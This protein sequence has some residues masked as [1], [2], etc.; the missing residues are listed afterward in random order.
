[1]RSLLPFLCLL[2]GAC[3]GPRNLTPGT[4][5]H[6]SGSLVPNYRHLEFWAAHPWKADPSDSLPDALRNASR[7]TLA[8]VFFI[9]PTTYTGKRNG[10]NADLSDEALNH[11]TD[12]STILY[13]ASVFNQHA[14]VFAPRYRQAH[15]SAFFTQDSM[16]RAA[17]DTAYADVRQAFLTYLQFYNGGRP[18]IIAGHSQGAL[19]S[20]WL[21]REFFDGKDLKKQLVAAYIIGWP[22]TA[23]E[24]KTIPI[25][26]DSL[27]TG[28]FCSWRTFR[29]DY[30]PDYILREDPPALVTNPLTWTTDS[31]YA[32]RQRNRGSV[33]RNF[34]KIYS[35]T[36]DAQVHDGVLWINRPRFPGGIF[37]TL[38]NYHIADINLFYVNLRMNVEQRIQA[39]YAQK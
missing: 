8:D 29:R 2:L 19:L 31:V 18:I 33:L 34:S 37:L 10:W 7:D 4:P 28:C 35:H 5:V 9:H 11:S 14:R 32:G 26:R 39:W 25:C 15:L 22:A 30:V 17:F 36:T 3:A 27:Q 38:Q 6:S 24:F 12:G 21:L 1:M 20:E 23:E 13:Q 16:A